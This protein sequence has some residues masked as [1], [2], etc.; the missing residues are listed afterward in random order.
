MA[1]RKHKL[2]KNNTTVSNDGFT[3]DFNKFKADVY[4]SY[5]EDVANAYFEIFPYLRDELGLYGNTAKAILL[6]TWQIWESLEIFGNRLSDL[7]DNEP[8]VMIEQNMGNDLIG[9][10][11]LFDKKAADFIDQYP[12]SFNDA[13]CKIRHDL[14]KTHIVI[15]ADLTI[16]VK[17]NRVTTIVPFSKSFLGSNL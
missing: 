4:N 14:R 9:T 1:K 12:T 7:V 5:P 6:G 16:D 2:Q 8:V 17:G 10:G 13:L 15:V 3:A 11:Y